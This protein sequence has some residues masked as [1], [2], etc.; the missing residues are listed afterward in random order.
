MLKEV[1]IHNAQALIKE[2]YTKNLELLPSYPLTK[3]QIKRWLWMQIKS[4]AA[5]EIVDLDTAFLVKVDE[6]KV[7]LNKK[8]KG[9]TFVPTHIGQVIYYPGSHIIFETIEHPPITFYCPPDKL[10]NFYI[11]VEAKIESYCLERCVVVRENH[12]IFTKLDLSK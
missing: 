10:K 6:H 2:F 5:G 12:Q 11:W 1:C 9:S 4:T 8:L 7:Y 3:N